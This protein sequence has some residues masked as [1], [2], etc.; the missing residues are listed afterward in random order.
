M[1][2]PKRLLFTVLG[3][4]KRSLPGSLFLSFL[5]VF[6]NV[7]LLTTSTWLIATA[8]L[9]PG[10]SALG[11]AIVGVRFFGISRAVSRYFERYISHHM[12]FQG[13]YGLRVWLY[14]QIEPLAPAIFR[15]MGTGELLTRV[16]SDIELL[17]FYYLRVL[18]PPMGALTLTLLLGYFLSFFSLALVLLLLLAF[19][20]SGLLLPYTICCLNAPL[21]VEGLQKRSEAKEMSVEML[22]GMLDII[23]YDRGEPVRKKVLETFSIYDD[24]QSRVQTYTNGGNTLFL[25]LTQLVMVMG[26]CLMIPLVQEGIYGGVYIAT[27]AICLQ[28]YFEALQPMM[29]AMHHAKESDEAINRLEV[30][31]R[32][33][34]SM[35]QQWQ[36]PSADI[37][38]REA[39]DFSKGEIIGFKNVTFSYEERPIFN[40]LS[41]SIAKG[42]KVAIVGPSGSGKSTIFNILTRSYPYEGRV[43]VKGRELRTLAAD[44]VRAQYSTLAQESYLFHASI[45]D[46]IRLAKPQAMTEEIMAV[47]KA[48]GL[49][50]FVCNLPQRGK[51]I[52]GSGGIGVSGGQQQRLA[53]ARILVQAHDILLLDEPLEGLDQITRQE[54]HR[55]LMEFGKD[56]TVLY[57]T[58]Q[59]QDLEKMNRIFFMSQGK[60]EEVGTY[61]ELMA[62]QGAFYHYVMLSMARI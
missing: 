10:L 44:A 36:V 9:H 18:I 55:N 34:K 14:E 15:R 20:V 45:E 23:S 33:N 2:K 50:E 57:I 26:A 38:T 30:L 28:S 31:A 27:I 59:L 22:N 29:A 17:Q 21:V 43:M 41:F 7:A 13:L 60:L 56:K 61:E 25:G 19:T 51:T 1:I 62:R 24:G 35:E 32:K 39:E 37:E 49:W 4:A 53:L 8:A 47:L 6:F 16:M 48:V 11:L 42:E 58:H 3:P 52:I 54:L 5:T 46:N 40:D 12:A